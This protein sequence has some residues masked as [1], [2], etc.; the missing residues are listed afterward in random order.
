MTSGAWSAIHSR[1]IANLRKQPASVDREGLRIG[2]QYVMFFAEAGLM[3][4]HARRGTAGLRDPHVLEVG[5]GLGVFAEQLFH[6]GVGSYTAVEPH[7]GVARLSER[8]VLD[9]WDYKVTVITQPW[10]L[11]TFPADAYDMIMYDTWPP[12]GHADGDFAQFVEHVALPCLRP[13]GRF[14]FFN[15]GPCLSDTRREVLDLHFVEWAVEPY[16]LPASE[17]P[18][19]WTKPTRDF[20]IPIAMKGTRT[21]H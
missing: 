17:T 19:H 10:Q 15:S 21:R 8:R 2:R 5:L 3:L 12:E 14:S 1:H 20:L 16:A 13:G 18:D 11:V 6:L 7:Y 4:T 9:R